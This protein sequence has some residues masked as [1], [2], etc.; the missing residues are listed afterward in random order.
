MSSS[1]WQHGPKWLTTPHQWP[2]SPPTL[3]TL[4]LAAAVATEFV[5]IEQPPP[6]LGLHCIIFI[7]RHGSLNKLLSV[8]AHVFHFVNNLRAPLQQKQCRPITADK[9]HKMNLQWV[10]DTQLTVY[11]KEINNLQLIVKQ[12][13]TPRAPVVHQLR[14][15]LGCGGRIHNAPVSETTKFP[16]LLPS[17]YS[18]SRLVILDIHVRL[19]HSGTRPSPSVIVV[20]LPLQ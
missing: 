6:D 13:K 5:P 12:P 3:P 7:N 14:L 11:R 8:T 19:C 9:L 2:S 1:L 18:L 17:R 10:K 20:R 15:F 16:Y 4:A